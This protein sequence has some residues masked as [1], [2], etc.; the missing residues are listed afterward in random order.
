MTGICT[1]LRTTSNTSRPSQDDQVKVLPLQQLERG[2]TVTD[3]DHLEPRPN[4]GPL[5]DAPQHLLVIDQQHPPGLFS[6]HGNLVGV[7]SHVRRRMSGRC[8]ISAEG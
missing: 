2:A 4:Q 1:S 3:L 6:A 5:E 7:A 8:K